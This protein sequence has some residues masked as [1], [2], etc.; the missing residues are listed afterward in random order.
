MK[1]SIDYKNLYILS[2]SADAFG[3]SIFGLKPDAIKSLYKN[4]NSFIDPT[5]HLKNKLHKWTKKG[6]YSYITQMNLITTYFLLTEHFSQ[7]KYK[8]Y[9][10]NFAISDLEFFTGIFRNS[11]SEFKKYFSNPLLTPLTQPLTFPSAMIFPFNLFFTEKQKRLDAIIQ[12]T[13]LFSVHP[14]TILSALMVSFGLETA[15]SPH[16]LQ[17]IHSQFIKEESQIRLSLEKID[18]LSSTDFFKVITETLE[19]LSDQ[20]LSIEAGNKI[21]VQTANH[22]TGQQ[23]TKPTHSF[24]LA[25][26]MSSLFWVSRMKNP[27]FS[28]LLNIVKQGGEANITAS[29][30]SLFISLHKAPV[31][32]E[33][34][35]KSLANYKQILLYSK[36][37]EKGHLTGEIKE[38][39][40]MEYGLTKSVSLELNRLF[41]KN[42]KQKVKKTKEKKKQE[43]IILTPVLPD[44][45][46]KRQWRDYERKKSKEK[47][48]RRQF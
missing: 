6:Y 28:N 18:F 19:T 31:F 23:I 34:L 14:L 46:D 3:T 38:P 29:I 10:K 48:K 7:K 39:Y 4:F 32:S 17:D 33:D 44:K 35:L 11:S 41:K 2:A 30:T 13:S 45:S 24:P 47:K 15:S 42:P 21:I 1:H 36:S 12:F 27:N 8:E 5:P 22:Y 26:V 16:L 43:K 25:S 9:L 40:K 37:M 20:N